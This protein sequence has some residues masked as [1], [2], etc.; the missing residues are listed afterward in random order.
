MKKIKIFI[1]MS[2]DGYVAEKEGGVAFLGGDGTEPENW[3]SFG[4]F[5][6]TVSDVIM[7]YT[8]YNQVVTELAPDNYPY[9]GKK[10]YVL[11]RKELED[12]E[13]IFFMSKDIKELLLELK[14]QEGDGTIWIN[15]GASIV[16]QVLRLNLA[17]EILVSVIPTILGSGI[18]LFEELDSE[19]KLELI[20]T[21]AYNGIVDLNY[22]PR[23]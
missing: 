8:T 9:T 2:L 23:K 18:K 20:S 12:K 15:G 13:D 22:K 1:A 19:I 4:E 21:T 16:N 7:G 5:F 10:S 14:N 17:D 6:E 11:T 3:G